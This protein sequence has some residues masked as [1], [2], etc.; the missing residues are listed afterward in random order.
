VQRHAIAPSGLEIEGTTRWSVDDW[1]AHRQR[2]RE[3]KLHSFAAMGVVLRK[4][5]AEGPESAEAIAARRGALGGFAELTR[6]EVADAEA[7]ARVDA[8]MAKDGRRW[9]A[10]AP[11]EAVRDAL[12]EAEAL[13]ALELPDGTHEARRV[14]A[15]AAHDAAPEL[16]VIAFASAAAVTDGA[17][18]GV[19][20]DLY[21][22]RADG[23]ALPP[24]EVV[25]LVRGCVAAGVSVDAAREGGYAGAVVRA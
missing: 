9:I 7:L 24:A 15:R 25:S 12:A 20:L 17:L 5:P 22:V 11:I 2:M 4:P 18:D 16:P 3:F 1:P 23:E 13:A 8:E 6:I 19:G 21:G 10:A 14:A